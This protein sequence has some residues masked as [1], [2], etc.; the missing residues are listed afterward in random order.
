MILETPVTDRKILGTVIN[1]DLS[2]FRLNSP[3]GGSS[4]KP[5][6]FFENEHI[7]ARSSK[8][9]GGGKPADAGTDDH[10]V[11][12]KGVH[13]GFDPNTSEAVLKCILATFGIM[14]GPY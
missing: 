14:V 6:T 8:P 1:A 9:G 7:A 13:D 2:H 4:S 3:G 10:N 5:A 12:F 11:M